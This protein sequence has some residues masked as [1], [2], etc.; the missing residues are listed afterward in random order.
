MKLE[1]LRLHADVLSRDGH[2]LGSLS[3]F[4]FDTET[5][6]V[7]HIV[8]DTGILRSGEALWKGG[9]GLSHDR[10]V[11]IGAVEDATS[12]AVR[13]T[14]SAEEFKD[15]AQDYAEEY[16]VQTPDAVKGA[17]DLSDVRRLAMSLPGEPGPYL[18]GMTRRLDAGEA[19]VPDDAPVWRL[20]PHQKIGEVERVIYDEVTKQLRALVIRRG[21]LF[22]KDVVLPAEHIVEVVA[23]IVRVQLDDAALRSLE[24]FEPSD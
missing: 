7:T 6:R 12:D 14:M 4:V 2:K 18:M 19:A 16:F 21:F 8:V 1:D 17:P 22:S 10:L 5:M 13:I 23:G 11:P 9:W 24:T 3:K 20:N 15:H